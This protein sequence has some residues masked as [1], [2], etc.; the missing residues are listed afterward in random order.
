MIYIV[1]ILLGIISGILA[2]GKVSNLVKLEFHR[3]WLILSAAAI[4]IILQIIESRFDFKTK[5]I[6]IFQGVVF[7][8]LFIGFWFNRKYIGIWAIWLGALC[9]MLVMSLNGGKMPVSIEAVKRAKL[10]ID[11]VVSETRHKMV[12]I[13]GSTRLPFLADIIVPPGFLGLGMKIVSIGD[14]IVAV[15]LF[16]LMLQVIMGKKMEENI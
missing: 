3:A 5:T 4:L 6:I 15:G 1:A 10:P 13:S 14:M 12:D 2:K 9:N 16:I 8:L 7:I 11:L